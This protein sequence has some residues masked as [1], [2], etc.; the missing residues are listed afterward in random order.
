MAEDN[1][2]KDGVTVKQIEE[3]AKKYRLSIVLSVGFVLAF[4][5]SFLF[6]GPGWGILF[7]S[8]GGVLGSIFPM[9]VEQTTEKSFQF[10]AK[11]EMITQII[12]AVVFIL[13]SIFLPF[14]IYFVAGL[15][16]GRSLYQEASTKP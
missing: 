8:I 12:F 2:K 10:I 14:L 15:H 1:P 7:A 6:F 3:F 9:I 13:I 11:Q 5:F 4:F 16:G